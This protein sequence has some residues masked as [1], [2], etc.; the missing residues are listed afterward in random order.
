MKWV[1]DKGQVLLFCFVVLPIILV[2]VG[3]GWL[4]DDAMAE[5]EAMY[6]EDDYVNEEDDAV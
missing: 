5:E 3:I 1:A 4:F 6:P 2:I